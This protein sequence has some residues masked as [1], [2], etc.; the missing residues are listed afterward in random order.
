MKF[1]VFLTK[2]I[3]LPLGLMAAASAA[4]VGIEKSLH[5]SRSRTIRG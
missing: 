1:T 4:G 2:N 5:E 3:L